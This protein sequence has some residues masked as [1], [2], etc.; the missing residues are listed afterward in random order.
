MLNDKLIPLV[1]SNRCGEWKTAKFIFDTDHFIGLQL[2]CLFYIEF[3]TFGLREVNAVKH[4][5]ELF[6]EQKNFGRPVG[7]RSMSGARG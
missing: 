3:K 2:T 6:V 4:S 5:T 7:T 1:E